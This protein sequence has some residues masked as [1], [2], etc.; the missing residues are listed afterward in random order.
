MHSRSRDRTA[1]P[2]RQPTDPNPTADPFIQLTLLDFETD[3]RSRSCTDAYTRGLQAPQG[4]TQASEAKRDLS[5]QLQWF[6]ETRRTVVALGRHSTDP[7][8]TALRDAMST[9]LQAQL[10]VT[11]NMHDKLAATSM[12]ADKAVRVIDTSEN[13]LYSNLHSAETVTGKFFDHPLKRHHP[14]VLV[15]SFLGLT[16][17]LLG[18]VT[19]N[20]CNFTLNVLRTFTELALHQ[21]GQVHPKDQEILDSFPTDIRTAR[22]LFDV[23]PVVTEWAACPVCS[24]TYEPTFTPEI[25]RAS[26]R[27]RVCLYV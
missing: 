26:C 12:P 5:E 18:G 9:R 10:A 1:L 17:H 19:R 20:M 7:A 27:E 21:G 2:C 11:S 25:G 22:R 14:L 23:D 24:M 3:S 6:R 13:C 15:S 16:L 8:T 4:S